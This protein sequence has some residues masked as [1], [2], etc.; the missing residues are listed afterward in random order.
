MV[1][2]P[3]TVAMLWREYQGE[4][5]LEKELQLHG[6]ALRITLSKAAEKALAQRSRVLLAEME[7]YFSCL[8][9]KA[10]RFHEQ[11]GDDSI[12]VTDMLRLRFRPVMTKYCGTDYEGD[13]PPLADFPIIQAERYV[14]HWVS[15][16]YRNGE[17]TGEFGYTDK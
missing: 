7:L 2:S 12:P 3:K 5:R 15:I 16:D 13:E 8:I 1:A 9:R 14:P 11:A 17:W 10:V 4:K 6:K